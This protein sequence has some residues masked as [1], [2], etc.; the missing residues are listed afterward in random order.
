VNDRS[1]PMAPLLLGAMA[2]SLVAGRFE[3]AVF[4]VV[5][6]AVAAA[7]AGAPRPAAGW[8]RVTAIGIVISVVLNL[9]LIPGRALPWPIPFGAHAS[10]EGL[11]AGLLLALRL[12]GA[13]IA[14]HGLRAA[15]PGERAADEGAR[16][17]APLGRLRVPVG[18]AR[19]VMGLAL[20]FAPLL[21]DEAQ[22]I[23]RVQDLRAG[24]P[25]RGWSERLVRR[26]AAAVPAL[27]SSLER[28]EQVALTLEA[29]HYRVRPPAPM[30]RPAWGWTAA[31][32]VVAGTAL[33]WRH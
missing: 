8:W 15:W 14:V 27:V 25:A 18:E 33:L 31:G 4:C 28:A 21:K 22:R 17:L 20:R 24:R 9:Y 3:S 5:L 23:A 1:A 32:F 12:V 10:R 16:L 26:R 29:R 2:G 30:P 7:L 13:T 6:A 11:E 19:M